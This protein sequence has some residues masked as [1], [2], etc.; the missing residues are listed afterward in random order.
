MKRVSTKRRTKRVFFFLF[1]SSDGKR[2]IITRRSKSGHLEEL[3]W[4]FWKDY[5][6]YYVV[7]D[8]MYEFRIVS[9]S[10]VFV[11]YVYRSI[12]KEFWSWDSWRNRFVGYLFLRGRILGFEILKFNIRYFQVWILIHFLFL[13]FLYLR[14][15]F[16]ERNKYFKV[17]SI[18]CKGETSFFTFQLS[19]FFE[20]DFF[21]KITNNFYFQDFIKS[22]SLPAYLM[23]RCIQG[24]LNF[25]V[26]STMCISTICV[27]LHNVREKRTKEKRK[28]G[29]REGEGGGG[30]KKETQER[31]KNWLLYGSGAERGSLRIETLACYPRFR[32]DPRPGPSN[33]NN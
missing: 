9:S 19:K 28:R 29:R 1:F 32:P 17:F 16:H 7:R 2:E 24:N 23:H 25:F 13:F 26:Y 14:F 21:S 22:F 15:S 12:S 3:D 8:I 20:Y 5:D 30:G 18:S 11:V 27:S 4:S 33:A 6:C 31:K 10:R